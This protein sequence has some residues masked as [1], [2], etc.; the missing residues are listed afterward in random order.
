[1]VPRRRVGQA[2]APRKKVAEVELATA[3]ASS[4]FP[5]PGSPYRMTPF[6]GLIPMSSYLQAKSEP[7]QG[8]NRQR[9]PR[10][11]LGVSAAARRPP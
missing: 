10:T 9:L 6:G 3:L 7:R 2:Y 1:M 8:H 5:V 11:V 4:V